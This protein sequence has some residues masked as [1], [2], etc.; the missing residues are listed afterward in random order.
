MKATRSYKLGRRADAMAA[1][2]K[3]ILAAA[4]ALFL[5]A[6]FHEVSVDAIAD[7]AKVGRTTVFEQFGSKTGLLREV[8]I[9]VSEQAGTEALLEQLAQPDARS[10]LRASFELGCKV[11]GAER[12]M[13]RRLQS[14][15]THD[16][17]MRAVLLEKDRLRNLAV[18]HL[19]DRLAEQGQL[20]GE[21]AHAYD[22]YSL[23]TSFEAFDILFMRTRSI[24]RTAAH[25]LTLASAFLTR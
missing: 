23:L 13:F 15:A 19:I 14:L 21:K 22:L 11:W 25:L 6:G 18:T 16:A 24:E 5:R 8:V 9:A 17:E 2:R 10:A 3:K 12:T 1:T 4:R 7:R 20:R